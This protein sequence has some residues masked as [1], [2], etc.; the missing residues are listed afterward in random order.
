MVGKVATRFLEQL[1]RSGER[2]FSISRG[3]RHRPCPQPPRQRHFGGRGRPPGPG[4]VGQQPRQ[5][6]SQDPQSQHRQSD[7]QFTRHGFHP[8]V[9]VFA[10]ENPENLPIS[11]N[12][13]T[14]ASD[15]CGALLGA[16]ARFNRGAVKKHAPGQRQRS[17]SH[18]QA[19]SVV[20]SYVFSRRVGRVKI[21]PRSARSLGRSMLS[22]FLGRQCFE[23]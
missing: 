21:G 10:P 23:R 17:G 20:S 8:L 7:L 3:S 14:R 11:E 13:Y 5:Q 18:P 2:I 12:A 15:G 16:L 19:E 4:I 9:R 6:Y 22:Q 1:R